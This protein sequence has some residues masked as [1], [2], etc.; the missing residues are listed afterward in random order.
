M[1]FGLIAVDTSGN[2]P[3]SSSLC[4]ALFVERFPNGCGFQEK[5]ARE[6]ALKAAEEERLKIV[7]VPQYIPE[8]TN[9]V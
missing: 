9:R 1:I 7:V 4:F 8:N 6:K 5:L 2:R 3:H